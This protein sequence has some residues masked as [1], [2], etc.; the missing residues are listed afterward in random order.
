[1]QL[2]EL[3]GPGTPNYLGVPMTLVP[4]KVHLLK[5]GLLD[6]PFTVLT[7]SILSIRSTGPKVCVNVLLEIVPAMPET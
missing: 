4:V 3:E 2:T 6:G 5:Y 7:M 1:M